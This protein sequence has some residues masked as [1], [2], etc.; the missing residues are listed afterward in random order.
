MKQVC[1]QASKYF[2]ISAL[3]HVFIYQ[4]KSIQLNLV[5]QVLKIFDI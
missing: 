2:K 3:L 5:F 4:N 1:A